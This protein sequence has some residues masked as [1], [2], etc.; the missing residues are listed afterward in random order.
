MPQ[1]WIQMLRSDQHAPG[2]N[3]LDW[4]GEDSQIGHLVIMITLNQVGLYKIY[5]WVDLFNFLT[6]SLMVTCVMIDQQR[7]KSPT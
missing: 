6:A 7:T 4:N 3:F 1:I 2:G 5:Q